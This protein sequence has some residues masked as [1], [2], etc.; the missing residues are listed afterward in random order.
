MT[1]LTTIIA[2]IPMGLKYGTSGEYLQG[3]ALVDIGGLLAST[4]LSLLLLPTLY[5]MTDRKR[6]GGMD[7]FADVD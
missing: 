5:K 4:L 6:K 2:M 1:T 7:E 3:L